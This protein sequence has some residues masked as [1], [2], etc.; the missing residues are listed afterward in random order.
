MTDAERAVDKLHKAI[1]T[2]TCSRCHA[3]AD[4]AIEA[5]RH[6]ENKAAAKAA[7]E[8]G[9]TGIPDD[10][11]QAHWDTYSSA[12]EDAAKDILARI[13]KEEA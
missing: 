10:I 11:P 7:W 3:A 8:D 12:R 9:E 13:G 5:T 2:D 1:D 6:D 4:H